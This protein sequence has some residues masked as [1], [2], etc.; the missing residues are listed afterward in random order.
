MKWR[1]KTR[2]MRAWHV[3]NA[4]RYTYHANNATM[5]EHM[6][7]RTT[8]AARCGQRSGRIMGFEAV[9]GGINDVSATL[10]FLTRPQQSH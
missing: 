6:E 10:D 7:H 4:S 5:D 1:V 3:S 9:G 2:R 8:T